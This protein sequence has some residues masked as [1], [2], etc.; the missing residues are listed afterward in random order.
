MRLCLVFLTLGR[1]AEAKWKSWEGCFLLSL[2]EQHGFKH[3]PFLFGMF[4]EA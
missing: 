2:G 1:T 4:H 3:T